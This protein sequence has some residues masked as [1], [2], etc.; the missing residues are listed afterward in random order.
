[1][2]TSTKIHSNSVIVVS[3]GAR[4]VTAQCVIELARQYYCRFILLG[5]SSISQGEPAWAVG[6]EDEAELKRQIMQVLLSQGQ[7]PKPLVVQQQYRSI[8][9]YRE[10]M[11]TL[12]AIEKVGGRAEYISVDVTDGEALS[13]VI[14]QTSATLGPITGIIHGAGTLADKRIEHKTEQDFERVYNTKVT[15]FNNLLNSVE[16]KQLDFLILFSSF[17]GLYGNAGQADYALANEILNKS[18]H[19]LQQRY[20]NCRVIAIGWGPW[21]GGMVTAELKQHFAK[22]NMALIPPEFG[23]KVVASELIREQSNEPQLIVM[24]RPITLST[25]SPYGDNYRHRVQR[26][27]SLAANPFVVDHVIGHQPVLPA[28]CGLGWIA[29][30]GEQRYPGYR[31]SEVQDFKVLKGIVFDESMASSYR[32]DLTENQS[33]KDTITLEAVVWSESPR[34]MPRYHYRSHLCLLKDPD[35][36]PSGSLF[37]T[38]AVRS[39]SPTAVSSL[40]QDGTLFHQPVFQSIRGISE[41]DERKL[42]CQCYLPRLDSWQQGQF[43]VQ[44]FNPYTADAFFQGLLV[45]VRKQRGLASLPAQLKSLKQFKPL[46]FDQIFELSLEI[47]TEDNSTVTANATACDDAG[48]VCLQVEEMQVVKSPRLKERFLENIYSAKAVALAS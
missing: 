35:T 5:R 15:G 45:W 48:D 25:G 38:T 31:F 32:L 21:D 41:L 46:L 24:S 27:I 1:M 28:M 40:Y 18:A 34:K 3:G 47:L 17:V 4:G 13:R 22:L 30:L 12:K 44:S 43:Q 14:A 20:P 26:K 6:L 16:P 33:T 37:V 11:G 29:N 9:A 7:K 23:A 39:Y 8:K 36:Q 2:S 42:R 19:R 10:I